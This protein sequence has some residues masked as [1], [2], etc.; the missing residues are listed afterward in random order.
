MS[1]FTPG[2]WKM[3]AEAFSVWADTP[4]DFKIA[5]IR[6]WGYLTGRG[7]LNLADEK[8]EAIQRANG[9]LIAA[10]P[11]LYEAL[12][13]AIQFV[14]NKDVETRCLNALNKARGES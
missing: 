4:G 10:S 2:P 9:N 6:G 8:A 1:A 7:G 11:D 5:D 13:E 14:I 3:D 12:K